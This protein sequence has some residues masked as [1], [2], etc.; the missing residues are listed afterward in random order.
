MNGNVE[1]V[2][3]MTSA[4][5]NDERNKLDVITIEAI[6]QCKWNKNCHCNEFCWQVLGNMELLKKAKSYE[7]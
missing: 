1:R 3:S 2:F 6:L 7:K 4:Q 5:R